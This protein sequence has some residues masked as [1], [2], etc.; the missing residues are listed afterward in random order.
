MNKKKKKHLINGE[1]RASEVRVTDEG[2][3]SI[4]DANRLASSKEMDL[5]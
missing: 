1:I 5:V 4:Q 2:V 3:M